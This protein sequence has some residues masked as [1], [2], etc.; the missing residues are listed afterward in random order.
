MKAISESFTWRQRCLAAGLALAAI[1][2]LQPVLTSAEPADGRK[3][4][5]LI[6]GNEGETH[7]LEKTTAQVVPDLAKEGINCS[8]ST[9]PADLNTQNLKK[10]DVVLLYAKYDSI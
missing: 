3:I 6:L 5:V 2:S 8:Y 9:S 4:E 1:L 10:F 7:A